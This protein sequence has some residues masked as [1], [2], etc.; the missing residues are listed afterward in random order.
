VPDSAGLLVENSPRQIAGIEPSS[1][2]EAWYKAELE[3]PA[4]GDAA[5]AEELQS[6]FAEMLADTSTW[7][8]AYAPE[9]VLGA[10]AGWAGWEIGSAIWGTFF[11]EAGPSGNP[12]TFSYPADRW[13][14]APAGSWVLSDGT[15][16]TYPPGWD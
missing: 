1:T 9:L 10:G 14:V 7:D 2:T 15:G 11:E 6:E 8:W 4:G 12:E 16:E 3:A 5:T 13:Y